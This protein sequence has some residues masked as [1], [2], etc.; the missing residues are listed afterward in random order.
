MP[1][2]STTARAIAGTVTRL[3][4]ALAGAN[5]SGQERR[6]EGRRQLVAMR[7][8]RGAFSIDAGAAGN[9]LLEQARA[10]LGAGTLDQ[11]AGSP[12]WVGL[13]GLLDTAAS[14]YE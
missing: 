4:A 2:L 9:A 10:L 14:E 5:H 1:W 13:L 6:R 3:R 11:V 12:Q 7:K 8:R